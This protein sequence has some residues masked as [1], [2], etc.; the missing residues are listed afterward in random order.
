M[1]KAGRA[2]RARPCEYFICS[3]VVSNRHPLLWRVFHRDY[4]QHL[5][6]EPGKCPPEVLRHTF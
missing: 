6:S 5:T 2:H 3:F 1:Q 4:S